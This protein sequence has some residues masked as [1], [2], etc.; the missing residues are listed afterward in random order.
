MVPCA[1]VD[2]DLLPALAGQGVRWLGW[3]EVPPDEQARLAVYFREAVLPVLTPFAIDIS[4]P[5]PLLA[6]LSLNLALLLEPS[7]EGGEPRLAVVQVPSGLSRVVRLSDA[8]G[9][10]FIMLDDVIR[11]HLSQL[12][13]GQVI[14][15][16]ACFRMSRDAELE[17]DDEGGRTQLEL[18]ERE[19]RRRR[20]SDAIR[21]EIEATASFQLTGMLEQ[22]LDLDPEDVYRLAGPLDLRVLIA[23][24][25]LP[26]EALRDPP[27]HPVDLLAGSQATFS[28]LPMR[29]LLHHPRELRPQKAAGGAGR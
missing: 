19:I 13:P 2:D 14:R 24:C 27:L 18:V 5:F 29:P 4:R 17:L 10:A 25:D 21:L 8:S 20:R 9:T 1:L 12:F 3:A 11:A 26:I 28:A 16:V 6:S 22:Q 7:E 23:I 15:E